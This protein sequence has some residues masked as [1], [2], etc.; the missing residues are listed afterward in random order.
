MLDKSL[1][2]YFEDESKCPNGNLAQCV[3]L[4]PIYI[5]MVAI[6]VI[7]GNVPCACEGV[8]DTARF[9]LA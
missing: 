7:L 5:G 9:P 2:M 3:I 8:L 1:K 6:H 4:R